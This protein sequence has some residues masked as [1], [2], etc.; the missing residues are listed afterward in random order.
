MPKVAFSMQEKHEQHNHIIH[1]A[2]VSAV[3]CNAFFIYLPF[4]LFCVV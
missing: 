3:L 1:T 2:Q 4:V